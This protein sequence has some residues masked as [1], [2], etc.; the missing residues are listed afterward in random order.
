MVINYE[1]SCP[2]ALKVG[3]EYVLMDPI[4]VVKYIVYFVYTHNGNL[5]GTDQPESQLEKKKTGDLL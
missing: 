2:F 4:N 5:G 3:V 1:F